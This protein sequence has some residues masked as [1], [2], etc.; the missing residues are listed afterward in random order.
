MSAEIY[1]LGR[2]AYAPTWALQERLRR[3]VHDG[4]PETLLLC[5]HEPV[6]TLGHSARSADV[7]V[8]DG[9]LAARHIERVTTTRGGQVTYHGPGQLVAYPIVRLRGGVVRHVEALGEAVVRLAREH[10]VAAVWS[11]SPVGVFVGPRKLA[12]IGIH[13]QRRVA[14]HGLAMNVTAQATEPF[15]QGL[16]VPCGA[17]GQETTSLSEEAGRSL[18]VAELVEPLARAL[19][20]TL[21]LPP[22]PIVAETN[23]SLLSRLQ[24]VE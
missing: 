11:R 15:R 13:I 9:V 22:V 4:G 6:I 20:R 3:R 12:A 10:E 1:W 21:Q 5:E 14:I 24:V 2:A 7:L 16:F 17:A 19:C 23:V 8:D 18:P